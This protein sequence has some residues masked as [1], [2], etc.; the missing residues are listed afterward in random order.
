MTTNNQIYVLA[1]GYLCD[2]HIPYNVNVLSS[3]CQLL[4]SEKNKNIMY[5]ELITI[6]NHIDVNLI[7]SSLS[8]IKNNKPYTNIYV[9][10]VK[11]ALQIIQQTS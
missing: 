4:T 9:T 10:S 2:Q 6:H 7:L 11:H 5:S 8:I 1:H 3:V